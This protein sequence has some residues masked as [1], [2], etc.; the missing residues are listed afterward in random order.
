MA[1]LNKK[2]SYFLIALCFLV[3]TAGYIGRLNYSASLVELLSVY[4]ADRAA[5]G[6]VSS[7]FFFAYGVGQLVNGILSKKYNPRIM[8]S[9]ALLSA[10]V[11]NIAMPFAGGLAA[12]K[13][14]W[15]CN[16]IVQS[17]LWCTIIRTISQYVPDSILPAAILV[18][19]TKVAIGTFCAYGLSA[20]GIGIGYW[21]LVFFV[22]AG[23]LAATSVLWF[24][25]FGY[26]K[27]QAVKQCEVQAVP[28]IA[29]NSPAAPAP[30][31]EKKKLHITGVLVMF[32]LAAAVAAIVNGFVKDGTV[33]W[34]PSILY[35]EFGLNKSFSVILT[36]CLPLLSIFGAFLASGLYKRIKNFQ[37]LIAIL[38]AAALICL[39][40]LTLICL[41]A[42]TLVPTLILFMCI[43]CFMAAVNNLL[44][45]TIPLYFR[46]SMNSGMLAGVINTF[47]YAGSTLSTVLLGFIA[48]TRGW[49]A[50]F[51]VMT[52]FAAAAFAVNIIASLM[53][54]K[55]KPGKEKAA[56]KL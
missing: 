29:E 31:K 40:L 55:G 36:F 3:Y 54:K 18:M 35:E 38:Y 56:K 24:I 6:L 12:M 9:F 27:K 53:R 43:S 33:T 49:T 30:L 50:V 20:I 19:S 47:C 25:A 52:I 44:T 17:I 2:Q 32:L 7:F 21:K 42:K 39:V 45:S 11:I 5:G 10:A 23:V 15:M 48:D 1:Y 22:A 37:L 13:W 26:L 4:G 16:G 46:K 51:I 14:L 41:P 34:T 28:E 8:L